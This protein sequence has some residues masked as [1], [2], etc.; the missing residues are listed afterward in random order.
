M[1]ALVTGAAG[2]IGSHLV[3]RLLAKDY[4]VA[5]VDDLST[6]NMRNLVD[7]RKHPAFEFTRLDITDPMAHPV[8]SDMVQE[9]D[10]VFHLAAVVGVK[11]VIQRP[12][13]TI[14]TNVT[15]TEAILTMATLGKKRV[16]VAST[17]EVYGLN[18]KTPFKETDTLC[19]GET[20]VSRWG[21][22]CSKAL[23]EFLSF[24]Y[25]KQFKLPVSVVRFFNCSWARQ[26]GEYGMVVPNFVQ[27]AIAG[28]PLEVH[29]DGKQIR[30]FG[31]APDYVEAVIKIA[32]TESTVG[33][34][35]NIGNPRPVNIG[36]L[37]EMV[38][39]IVPSTNKTITYVSYEQVYGKNFQ[40]MRVRIPSIEKIHKAIGWFPK[41]SLESIIQSV[42][43]WKLLNV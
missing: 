16:I 26:T 37:A 5:G 24:A 15:G 33:E 32:E 35:Y 18:Q 40:D 14:H 17:S 3:D 12:V 43:A 25:H 2:F 29:G 42:Y 22:A 39:G 41:N 7:A 31:S 4:E 10:V 38:F 36:E 6:G 30:C 28:E 8:L 19:I 1:K 9:A 23:D 21:Y 27:R 11:L 13:D 20:T 34:V